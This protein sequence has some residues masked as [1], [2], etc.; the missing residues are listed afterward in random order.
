MPTTTW[1][2]C[3]QA[4][5]GRKLAR[6]RLSPPWFASAEH[7]AIEFY[8]ADSQLYARVTNTG[9]KPKAGGHGLSAGESQWYVIHRNSS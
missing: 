1:I 6:A 5:S 3:E 7:Y 4:P 8:R 9:D 2:P